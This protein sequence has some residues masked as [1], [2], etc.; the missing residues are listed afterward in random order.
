VP[1]LPFISASLE[2]EPVREAAKRVGIF[3]LLEAE[4]VTPITTG[5]VVDEGTSSAVSWAAV[6]A[7]G[8]AIAPWYEA[9]W[10]AGPFGAERTAR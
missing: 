6:L 1:D 8:F 9:G 2:H 7:G 10:R 3:S 5:S 4:M